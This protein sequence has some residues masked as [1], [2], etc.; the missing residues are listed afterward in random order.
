MSKENN[1]LAQNIILINDINLLA[2]RITG[3]LGSNTKAAAARIK[4]AAR[5]IKSKSRLISMK[6]KEDAGLHSWQ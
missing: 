3:D 5:D 1:T 2:D 4:D 6:F